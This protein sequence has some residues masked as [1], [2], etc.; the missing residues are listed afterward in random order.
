MLWRKHAQRLLVERGQADV[1]GQLIELAGDQSVDEVGLNVGAIHALW[2]LH[3]LGELDRA[4]GETY[5]AVVAALG[6]P[7]AG[8]R[9]NA[10]QVLPPEEESIN[11]ILAADL[12]SDQSLDVRLQ[13]VVALAEMPASASTGAAIFDLLNDTE[14]IADRWIGEA[15]AMAAAV[16]SAGYLGRADQAEGGVHRDPRRAGARA[17]RPRADLVA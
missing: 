8:V 7:S 16:H 13:T 5:E 17:V 9:R 10:V 6:H 1:A 2:T 12:L 14:N 3:G 4:G 15:G 11:A